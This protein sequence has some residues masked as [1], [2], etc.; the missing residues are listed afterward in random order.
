MPVLRYGPAQ[1]QNDPQIR[2]NNGRDTGIGKATACVASV[3]GEIQSAHRGEGPDL[4]D[5]QLM[6]V[7]RELAE[8]H[9]RPTPREA[10]F[11]ES[12][13]F[14]TTT[15]VVARRVRGEGAIQA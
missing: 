15:P 1:R 8:E 14:I 2:E 7:E 9:S 10:F 11:D 3:V 12:Y 6:D 4:A 13:D 5:I